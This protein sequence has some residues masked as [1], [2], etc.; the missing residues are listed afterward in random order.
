MSWDEEDNYVYD[1]K[2]MEEVYLLDRREGMLT[3]VEG[4]HIVRGFN[5]RFLAH[6]YIAI[7]RFRYTHGLKWKFTCISQPLNWAF[8][9]KNVTDMDT[10]EYW[11]YKYNKNLSKE[12][13]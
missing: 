11:R 10:I 2:T 12:Q 9:R 7:A 6:V 4:L 8:T 3:A 1:V 13:V 5:S